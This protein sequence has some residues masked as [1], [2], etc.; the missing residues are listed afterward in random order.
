MV[1]QKVQFGRQSKKL[2]IQSYQ[3]LRNKEHLAYIA[4]TKKVAQCR[5]WTFNKNV[6]F[7][8]R[9]LHNVLEKECTIA[10]HVCKKVGYQTFCGTIFLI[11]RSGL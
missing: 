4:L 1:L 6:N 8:L 11:I 10:Y 5:S 9:F 3:I 7:I 2:Q